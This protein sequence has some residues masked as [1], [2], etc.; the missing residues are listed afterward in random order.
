[1]GNWAQWMQCG[2]AGDSRQLEQRAGLWLQAANLAQGGTEI[3]GADSNYQEH[4][5]RQI[6]LQATGRVAWWERTYAV[7]LLEAIVGG[8]QAAWHKIVL[9]YCFYVNA[10][11]ASQRNSSNTVSSVLLPPIIHCLSSLSTTQRI[12]CSPHACM[13]CQHACQAPCKHASLRP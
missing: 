7:L 1:M 6:T 13:P 12:W 5:L 9:R 3:K 4:K 8:R 10:L 11:Q 2:V